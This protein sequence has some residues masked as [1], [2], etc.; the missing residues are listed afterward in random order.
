MRILL[1]K[2]VTQHVLLGNSGALRRVPVGL[3]F[4]CKTAK[5]LAVKI[6]KFQPLV[7]KK[8]TVKKEILAKKQWTDV[9]RT[10]TVNRPKF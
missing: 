10:L 5:K 6:D 3:T 9:H 1:R 8:V 2:D 4:S 7:V